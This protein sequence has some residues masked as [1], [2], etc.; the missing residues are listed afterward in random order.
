MHEGRA[1]TS[2]RGPEV[3][4]L[5]A[6]VALVLRDVWAWLHYTALA[7]PR[8]GVRVALLE[9]LRWETLLLWLFHVA[10]EA[11]GVADTATTESA[12]SHELAG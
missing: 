5:Y 10:E 3:R 9:R 2:S 8:R 1:W 4:S 7:M 12:L 11:F 6:G